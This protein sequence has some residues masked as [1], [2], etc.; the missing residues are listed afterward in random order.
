MSAALVSC[1][2]HRHTKYTSEGLYLH[3]QKTGV[4]PLLEGQGQG[5][6]FSNTSEIFR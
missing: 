5:N 3:S 1:F 4:S 6:Q 2:K